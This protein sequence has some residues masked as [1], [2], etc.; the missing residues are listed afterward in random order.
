[1]KAINIFN[2][3]FKHNKRSGFTLIELIAVMA[4][5][6]ILSGVIL[7]KVTGYIKEAK[8]V[9]VVDECR[10]V[11]MA[12][13]SYNLKNNMELNKNTDL[14]K[15]IETVGIKKYLEGVVFSNI[16][17]TRTSLKNC[18]DILDGAEF[19]IND[20]SILE[21]DKITPKTNR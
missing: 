12:V 9:K 16:D 11:V 10:K 18:Y 2:L 8:K 14:T 7:P 15:V 5:I 6:A 3:K 20:Q 13:E 19:E 17:C 1:M 21:P 4:I